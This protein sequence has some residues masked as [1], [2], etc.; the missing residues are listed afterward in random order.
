MTRATLARCAAFL[1]VPAMMVGCSEPTAE[2]VGGEPPP[3]PAEL[4]RLDM[5]VG[6]W[7]GTAEMMMPGADEAMTST[8][9]NEATWELDKRFLVSKLNLDMGEHGTMEGLE[10][11]TWDNKAKTYRTWWFSSMGDAA[12]ATA[13]YDE[14]S[15][16]WHTSGV[17]T[18]PM[19]GKTGYG[20]GTIKMTDDNSMEWTW[21]EWDNMLHFGSPM[22]MKG[23]STKK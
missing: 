22:T 13:R 11:W 19:T 21:K 16:E 14:E 4:A 8:G 2:M 17:G 18:N 10:V 6:S 5:F 15:G 12:Q 20:Q 3:R 1:T 23:K 9:K 7:E